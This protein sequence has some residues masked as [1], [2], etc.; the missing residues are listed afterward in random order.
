MSVDPALPLRG[1]DG[2]GLKKLFE[3]EAELK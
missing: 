2:G 1:N 3:R